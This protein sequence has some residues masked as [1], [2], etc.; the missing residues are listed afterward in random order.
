VLGQVRPSLYNALWVIFVGLSVLFAAGFTV[1]V[2]R[3]FGERGYIRFDVLGAMIGSMGLG[4]LLSAPVPHP[5][6]LRTAVFGAFSGLTFGMLVE[7]K[8]GP[9]MD[10]GDVAISTLVAAALFPLVRWLAAKGY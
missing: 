6:W 8:F 3:C 7:M 1:I 10:A 4:A 9:P 2:M 5:A